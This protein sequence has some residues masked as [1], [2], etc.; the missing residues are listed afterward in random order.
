MSYIGGGMY[1]AEPC[2]ECGG[3]LWNGR[4]ENRD[5]I[6][7]WKPR[8]DDEQK[9]NSKNENEEQ[10]VKVTASVR[11]VDNFGRIIIPKE[12]RKK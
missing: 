11:K 2:P 9:P 4:C 12:I 3:T 5:C 8:E 1:Y 6:Y 10:K 7:H